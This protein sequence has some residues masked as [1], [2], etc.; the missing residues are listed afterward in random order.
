MAM[1]GKKVEQ[2]EADKMEPGS[3]EED[4]D[5]AEEGES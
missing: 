3:R 2:R 4:I 5:R 1:V